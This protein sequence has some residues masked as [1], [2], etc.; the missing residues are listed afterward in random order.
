MPR[1]PDNELLMRHVPEDGSAIGN[2]QLMDLLS[3]DDD[4]Y[5]RVRNKLVECGQLVVARGRG[6]SVKRQRSRSVTVGEAD[7]RRPS[8]FPTGRT[9]AYTDEA[10]LYKPIA[11]VLSKQWALDERLHPESL[12]VEITGRQ[13]RRATGG[14]WTRPDLVGV[15][16]KTFPHVPGKHIDIWTFEVKTTEGT[17][18]TAIYE[19]AA[20]SRS[21]T[22]SYVLLQVRESPNVEDADQDED[23]GLLRRCEDEA[24]RLHVGLITFTDPA[25]FKT[26]TRMVTAPRLNTDPQL[27]EDFIATQLSE[28]AKGKLLRW[29]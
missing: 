9:Q 24:R 22:R 17:D 15:S 19:A 4:K 21:A 1:L 16:V 14:T 12:H 20:H 26:W 29:R 28:E 7:A 10:G 5:F 3:W 23:G 13:G 25:N 2:Y 8:G 11:E 27:L 18:I 6:G